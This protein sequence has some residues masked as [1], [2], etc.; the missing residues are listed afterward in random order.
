MNPRKLS[1]DDFPH[2]LGES[3]PIYDADSLLESIIAWAD[4]K[5]RYDAHENLLWRLAIWQDEVTPADCRRWRDELVARGLIE[6]TRTGYNSY[7]G[8]IDE[9]VII[10]RTQYPRFKARP[11]IPV[12]VKRAVRARDGNRCVQC[13]EIDDLQFD[14]IH[15]YSKGGTETVENL[16]LLCRGCNM[17]KGVSCLG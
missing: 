6:I 17:A 14:H 10:N 12:T 9:I 8:A 2:D 4:S 3:R 11:A 15:P 13:G 16:Q 7:C 1:G 5:G